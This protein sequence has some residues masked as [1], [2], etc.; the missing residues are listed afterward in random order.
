MS[1]TDG[2]GD[3]RATGFVLVHLLKFESDTTIS[4]NIPII[5]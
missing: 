4:K 1:A 5:R 3:I 2:E